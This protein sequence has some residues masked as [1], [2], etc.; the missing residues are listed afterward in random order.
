MIFEDVFIDEYYTYL[1]NNATDLNSVGYEDLKCH[2][3]KPKKRKTMNSQAFL[4]SQLPHF[5]RG[6]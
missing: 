3:H 6:I 1:E 5:R 2:G 4:H